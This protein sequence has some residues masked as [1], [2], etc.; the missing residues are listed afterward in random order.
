MLGFYRH[1]K[2]FRFASLKPAPVPVLPFIHT[3]CSICHILELYTFLSMCYIHTRIDTH[4]H[5]HILVGE[6]VSCCFIKL[7]SH[8]IH[9]SLHLAI[10]TSQFLR[11]IW[12]PL[13]HSLSW[14]DRKTSPLCW[15]LTVFCCCAR[16]IHLRGCVPGLSV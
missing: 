5:A 8:Y 14:M 2:I 16:S 12:S 4:G 13:V 11:E 9:R 3:L 6:V 7:G 15:E 1:V 10:L